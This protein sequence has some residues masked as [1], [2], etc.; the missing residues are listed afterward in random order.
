[1]DSFG[2][3]HLIKCRCVLPQFKKLDNPPVHKFV[4]FSALN[5]EGNVVTKYAQ[6]NN[7][8]VIHKVTDL[9]TS[10]IIPGRSEEHT[11]ELQSH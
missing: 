11:S 6:C 10:E 7:C 5:E 9:C 4:V 1:M 8:G 3:K 2:Q